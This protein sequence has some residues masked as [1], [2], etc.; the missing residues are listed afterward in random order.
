MLAEPSLLGL[1][2]EERAVTFMSSKIIFMEMIDSLK[3]DG[4]VFEE[5]GEYVN[6]EIE[7]KLT[8]KRKDS[9]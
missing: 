6:K 3:R 9:G 2:E 4:K 7:V 8:P 1:W 5:C